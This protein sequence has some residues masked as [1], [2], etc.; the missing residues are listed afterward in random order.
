ME[1][2]TRHG[3]ERQDDVF[4]RGEDRVR[5]T[6]DPSTTE[7]ETNWGIP[8]IVW[9]IRRAID[10]KHGEYDITTERRQ[11]SKARN[12]YEV[13]SPYGTRIPKL[14]SEVGRRTFESLTG[15]TLCF[16]PWLEGFGFVYRESDRRGIHLLT[17]SDLEQ[18]SFSRENMISSAN[19]A[20]F[21]SGTKPQKHEHGKQFVSSDGKAC[22]V[23]ALFPDFI[24][25]DAADTAYAYVES[26]DR[27]VICKEDPK[28]SVAQLW[29]PSLVRVTSNGCEALHD[30]SRTLTFSVEYV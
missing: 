27:V 16:E 17:D 20:L 15:E 13:A 3:L 12:V 7:E 14:V 21:N 2:W 8:H 19:Y 26:E 9:G 24:Y 4:V 6:F 29:L 28:V 11:T 10:R 5:L 23:V 18:I 25:D 1:P 30:V 22:G